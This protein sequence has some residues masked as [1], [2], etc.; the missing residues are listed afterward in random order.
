MSNQLIEH[1]ISDFRQYGKQILIAE[2]VNGFLNRDDVRLVLNQNMISV[3]SGSNLSQRID[4][5][6]SGNSTLHLFLKNPDRHLEDIAQKSSS[7]S[8]SLNQYL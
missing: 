6:N 5:H 3:C 2:D 8:F 1:I 4:Y 7:I